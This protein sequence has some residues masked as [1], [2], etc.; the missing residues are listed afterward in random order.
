[1]RAAVRFEKTERL[2]CLASKLPFE[3]LI[4]I[5]TCSTGNWGPLPNFDGRELVPISLAEP[6]GESQ[7][8][9]NLG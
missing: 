8:S 1:M 4:W 3:L 2:G 7:V 9:R 5:H 6:V